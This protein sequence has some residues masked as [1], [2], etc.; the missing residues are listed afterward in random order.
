MEAPIRPCVADTASTMPPAANKPAASFS[1]AA[2][3]STHTCN[4]GPGRINRPS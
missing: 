4:G 1:R 2:S 3:T